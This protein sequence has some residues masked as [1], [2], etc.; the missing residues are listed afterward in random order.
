MEC[1]E[2]VFRRLPL[3]DGFNIF[4]DLAGSQTITGRGTCTGAMLVSYCTRKG[5]PAPALFRISNTNFMR[6]NGQVTCELQHGTCSRGW[7]E[8]GVLGV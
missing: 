7:M 4:L 5:F 2:G 3:D 8:G 6:S 1:G